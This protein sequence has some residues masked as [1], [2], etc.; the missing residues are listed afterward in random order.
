M[1]NNLLP[2]RASL[3]G[4]PGEL[5]NM[6]YSYLFASKYQSLL[7]GYSPLYAPKMKDPFFNKPMFHVC[8]QLRTEA[9]AYI[10]YHK[11][12]IFRNIEA[13]IHTLTTIG[14]SGRISL[15]HVEVVLCSVEVPS[16][17]HAEAVLAAH[18]TQLLAL[19]KEATS[20]EVCK[21]H[22]TMKI[23]EGEKAGQQLIRGLLSM[24]SC[25]TIEI[26]TK[27]WDP[28]PGS[29]FKE[30]EKIAKECG[31]ECTLSLETHNRAATF[32]RLTIT[33]GAV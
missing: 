22:Y 23:N 18:E 9:I 27:A 13:A 21:I 6:I 20:L 2:A 26:K 31:E 4:L 15:T 8:T 3:L 25:K 29:V 30:I 28:P 24:A 10:C 7:L 1:S 32:L 19:L 14:L 16:K 17:A 5:R 11:Q 12:F 33:K